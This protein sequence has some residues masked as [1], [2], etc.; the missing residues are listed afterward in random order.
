M[1]K[2]FCKGKIIDKTLYQSLQDLDKYLFNADDE[3]KQNRDWWVILDK[4][5][6]VAY[7]GCS[8]VKNVCI[9]VRA[10]V[11][12]DH[13]GKGIQKKMI[14]TRVRAAKNN[15]CIQ[16]ITYTLTTN[17]A[18]ANSLISKGFKLYE[19]QNKWVGSDVLYFWIGLQG[20]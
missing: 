17:Y 7:C 12:R 16:C 9:F 15:N 5:K 18:S 19:P 4:G 20:G 3:F 13:R 1:K 6:I 8:Y 14:S 11:Q 2:I 10:W